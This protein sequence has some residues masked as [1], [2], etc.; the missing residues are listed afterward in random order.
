MKSLAT[1]TEQ[2]DTQTAVQ[3]VQAVCNINNILQAAC[4]VFNLKGGYFY[5]RNHCKQGLQNGL[6]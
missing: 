5:E 3:T 2:G 4:Q 6:F 1:S